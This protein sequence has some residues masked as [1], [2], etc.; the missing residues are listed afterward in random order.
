MAPAYGGGRG[1][2]D[3]IKMPDSALFQGAWASTKPVL[4]ARVGSQGN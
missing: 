3:E 1:G 4:G 2:G